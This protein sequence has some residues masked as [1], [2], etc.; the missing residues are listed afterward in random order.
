MAI[1]VD[2]LM[3]QLEVLLETIFTLPN[4]MS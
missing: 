2:G 4:L 3:Y 1:T